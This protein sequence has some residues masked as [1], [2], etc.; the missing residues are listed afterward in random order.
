MKSCLFFPLTEVENVFNAAWTD[1][2][3]FYK[4]YFIC[5]KFFINRVHTRMD[6]QSLKP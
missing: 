5:V 3:H 6:M 1:Y 4:F 2:R